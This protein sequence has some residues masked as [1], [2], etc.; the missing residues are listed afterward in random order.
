MN[1]K[2][3]FVL[4]FLFLVGCDEITFRSIDS[5]EWVQLDNML[6]SL[7]E[8]TSTQNGH[9][10]Y[11]AGGFK[12]NGI[13]N[14]NFF[15]YDLINDNYTILNDLP[16]GLHHTNIVYLDNKIYLIGGW[17]D[18]SYE[19]TNYFFEYDVETD[20]W[21]NKTELPF[22]RAA[23]Q[24][25]VYKDSIYVFGGVGANPEKILKYNTSSNNW[26]IENTLPRNREHHSIELI[27]NKIYLIG[28]RWNSRNKDSIDIYNLITKEFKTIYFKKSV[29]G[30]SSTILNNQI[31]ILGGEDLLSKKTYNYNQVLNLETNEF[32]FKNEIPTYRHGHRSHEFNN[33][34]YLFGGAIG[35]EY[36][37][38]IT[39]T[40]MVHK[41]N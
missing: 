37:T 11:F 13:V 1:S 41:F 8:F 25:V 7:S 4:L 12:I 24:S 28:G 29:S 38:F 30:H 36:D 10:I 22:S 20:S 34:I 17:K 14:D 35:A 23:H 33:S 39:T 40:N 2:I 26:S 18:L 31:Y 16:L 32:K 6:I 27:D 15:K 5:G 3:L 21:I 9:E 19:A